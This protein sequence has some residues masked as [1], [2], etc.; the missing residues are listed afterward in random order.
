MIAP[1][2]RLLAYVKAM[3]Q[4]CYELVDSAL[5]SMQYLSELYFPSWD[6]IGDRP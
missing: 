2:D 3:R 6:A 5:A 4:A 1:N